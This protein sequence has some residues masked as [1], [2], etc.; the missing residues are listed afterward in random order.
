MKRLC[1]LLP[2]LTIVACATGRMSGGDPSGA[3]ERGPEDTFRKACALVAALEGKYDLLAG[4][5][6]VK[7]VIERDAKQR[8]TSAQ[9]AFAR[10]A[11][12][13]GKH[14]VEASDAGKPFVYVSVAIWAGRTPAPPA[15]L[16]EF[17]WQGHVYQMWVRVYG[18]DEELVQAI[19]RSVDEPLDG[20]AREPDPLL[21]NAQTIS[22][23]GAVAA[24]RVRME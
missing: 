14:A 2:A 11:A 24:N 13:P 21:C 3:P 20:S 8:L 7:P 22:Y 15:G 16:H 18:R 4:V 19:R 6:K 5:S 17:V 10:N 9:F 1:D 12:S 23:V